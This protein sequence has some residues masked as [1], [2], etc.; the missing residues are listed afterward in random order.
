M[1]G[2]VPT[3]YSFEYTFGS[4]ESVRLEAVPA[5][6]YE[7]SHWSGSLDGEDNPTT[8][9]MTCNKSITANFSKSKVVRTLTMRVS[10]NGSITPPAGSHDYDGGT[11]VS[12]VATPDSGWRF[13]GW[14]GNVAD[15]SSATTKL[16][17]NSNETV[18]ANFSQVAHTLTVQLN[19]NGSTNPAAGSYDYGEGALVSITATPN[20][21]WKFDDW[22]GDVADVSSAT[23]TLT[24]GSDKS[25]I[26]NFAQVMHALTV[27]V[28]GNG[29][30]TPGSGVHDYG[31]GTLV[32]IT[33]TVGDGWRFDGWTGD[34]ADPGSAMTTVTLDSDKVVTANFSEV[35]AMQAI[36]TGWLWPYGVIGG[37]ALAVVLVVV[38]IIRRS[39]YYD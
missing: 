37:L 5:S 29:S 6:G 8:I 23:T 30:T 7:F 3:Y 18:V 36:R 32:S 16:T 21:G 26:A 24:M 27:Q 28:N 20:N 34:V 17:M 10:G 2:I 4:E 12:I 39:H 14:T 35:R 25:V 22:T 13:V 11:M 38:K 1:N 15:A 33:A 31:E 9:E 19:G